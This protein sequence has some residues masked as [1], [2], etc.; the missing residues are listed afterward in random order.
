MHALVIGS[1]GFIGGYLCAYLNTMGWRVTGIDKISM[2]KPKAYELFLR[3]YD[4]RQKTQLKHLQ[5]FY[6]LDCC[7]AAEVS[8]IIQKVQP[9]VIINLASV[10]VADVCKKN[11]EEAVRSI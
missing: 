8:R 6:Q 11:T 5:D 4:I 3:H 10:S 1:H 9:D 7:H 2:Y